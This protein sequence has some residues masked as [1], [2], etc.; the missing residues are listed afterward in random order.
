MEAYENTFKGIKN[1]SGSFMKDFP[2][3]ILANDWSPGK[4]DLLGE[5]DK[6]RA[7]YLLS[8][9]DMLEEMLSMGLVTTIG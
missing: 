6:E 1:T 7:S 4:N 3:I 8:L 2:R 9:D 5:I